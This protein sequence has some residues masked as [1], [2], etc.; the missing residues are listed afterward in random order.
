MNRPFQ[1]PPPI[2]FAAPFVKGQ[3]RSGGGFGDGRGHP[4]ASVHGQSHRSCGGVSKG[5][6][7]KNG[8]F[9]KEK[10]VSSDKERES[11]AAKFDGHADEEGKILGEY[12]A[13]SDKLGNSS[14]GMLVNQIL[15]EEE[16]HH[17]LLRTMAKWLRE[18]PPTAIP[19]AANRTEL[20]RLTQEL[21]THEEETIDACRNLKSRVS[22]A[23]EGLIESLLDAM[24]L[25]SEKHH[26]LLV[27]VEKMLKA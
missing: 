12:R 26:R 11:L 13:L 16:V 9:Q 8:H 6:L 25:D 17:L 7:G 14:A 4:N 10:T 19:Q 20:L 22:K 3:P 24:V 21:Q 23:G 2:S 15:T 27:A 1:N 18:S 5:C